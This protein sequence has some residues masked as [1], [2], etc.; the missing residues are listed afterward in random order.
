MLV[1]ENLML[2]QI[3][4]MPQHTSGT[5]HQHNDVFLEKFCGTM[6]Y[7]KHIQPRIQFWFGEESQTGGPFEHNYEKL[8][9]LQKYSHF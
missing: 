3:N 5:W 8:I 2:L 1:L 4:T 7:C 9:L 6:S